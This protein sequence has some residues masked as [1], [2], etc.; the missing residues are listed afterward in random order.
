MYA[1][2][3]ILHSWMRWVVIILGAVAVWR[4]MTAASR[5]RWTPA[6]ARAAQ[7]FSIAMDVQILIGLVLFLKLS[8]I[9]DAA[10][11]HPMEAMRQAQFRFWLVEHPTGLLAAVAFLHIGRARIRR[12]PEA[13]KG[14]T[15]RL[16]LG[17]ALLLILV[18]MPWPG[19]PYGRP[20]LRWW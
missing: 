6:D 17:I 7:F 3:L 20:L 18:S 9:V 5:R 10:M 11:V 13:T 4:A 12:A 15:A 2:T 14:R 1:G 8:P 16:F 19:L